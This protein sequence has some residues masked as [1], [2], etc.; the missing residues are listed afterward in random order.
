VVGCH[1]GA[2]SLVGTV[3]KSEVRKGIDCGPRLSDAGIPK[4][5]NRA[6]YEE[7]LMVVALVELDVAAAVKFVV[8]VAVGLATDVGIGVL[9]CGDRL[10][11]TPRGPVSPDQTLY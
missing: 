2:P 10:I 7:G 6:L 3:A 11:P 4:V 9:S 5:S 8:A 1:Q